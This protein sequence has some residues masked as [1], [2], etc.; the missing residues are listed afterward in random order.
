MS[1]QSLSINDKA[2]L[3]DGENQSLVNKK[4]TVYLFLAINLLSWLLLFFLPIEHAK[5]II[6]LLFALSGWGMKVLPQ[7]IVSLLIMVYIPVL[8]IGTFNDS[9]RGF[10]QP[11]I[12]LLVATFLLASSVE[13]TGFGKRIALWLLD[14]AKGKSKL[15]LL[16]IYFTLVVLGFMIPTAAGRSAMI[17]P[18]GLGMIQI[19]QDKKL[20][21]NFSKSLMLG[22]AFTSSFI[23]WGL[24]TGSSSS[25]YAVSFIE[26]SIGF[27]WTYFSW[28]KYNFPPMIITLL[29][30]WMILK[31]LYPL[32]IE[33]TSETYKYI[34]QELKKL[35][36]MK[37]KEWKICLIGLFTIIGWCT[38]TLHGFSVS[39][40]ALFAGIMTC[41]PGIGVQSWKDG[42]KRISWDV[43]ILFGAGFAM[44]EAIVNNKT[45]DWMAYKIAEI[46]P[47]V[48]PFYVVCIMLSIILFIRLGFANMLAITAV[49]LP[50]AMSLSEIWGI[51]SIWMTQIVIIGCS[52]SYFLPIQ[53]PSNIICFSYGFFTEKDMFKS[54]SI[55]TVV[56]FVIVLLVSL[57]F[58]PL[59]GLAP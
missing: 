54:G 9:I 3:S 31:V 42:S 58:W 55:L 7:P 6:L 43:V 15:S 22:V 34:Q 32:P 44:A 10:S 39:M 56:N 14:R 12:W 38:E 45:A 16:Y 30:L 13:I 23:S 50:I 4:I 8:G 29:C 28:L 25:I 46:F 40:I 52:F 26:S 41:I 57:Y 5:T 33:K 24:I 59:L 53:S 1:G 18:I 27:K 49:F 19:N 2:Y 17:I 37:K 11:F 21:E 36:T 35:G 48:T 20:Y 51:N 47:V